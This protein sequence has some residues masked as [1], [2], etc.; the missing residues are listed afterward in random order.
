MRVQAWGWLVLCSLMLLVFQSCVERPA[1]S[2]QDRVSLAGVHSAGSSS[3]ATCH[4]S[5]F[6]KNH[7]P[8]DGRD[9]SWCHFT[10]SWVPGDFQLDGPGHQ[11]KAASCLDCHEIER[12]SIA[13]YPDGQGT[14]SGHYGKDCVLCHQPIYSSFVFKHTAAKAE[15][16]TFCLPCHSNIGRRNHGYSNSYFQGDGSCQNCH[17][18]PSWH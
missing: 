6:N 12:P 5:L 7:R 2:A 3:C 13:R 4:F 16:V 14:A 17:S 1:V 15:P 18:Y 10:T 9:C 11:P 8:T